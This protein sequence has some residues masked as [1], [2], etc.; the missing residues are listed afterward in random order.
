[1]RLLGFGVL[2]AAMLANIAGVSHASTKRFKLLV[3]GGKQLKWAKRPAQTLVLKYAFLKDSHNFPQARNCRR[4]HPVDA[5]AERSRL[6]VTALKREIVAGLRQWSAVADVV[7]EEA[8]TLA[9][10]DIV[11]GTR[12]REEG[13]AFADV[14][15]LGRSGPTDQIQRSLICFNAAHKWKIGFGGDLGRYDLRYVATHEAGHAIGLDHPG[16]SGELMS[17]RYGEDFR[18]L[19][20]GD[21]VGAIRLYGRARIRHSRL[22]SGRPH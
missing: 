7:F 18:G 8:S 16:R 22:I 17:F 19:Q 3:V 4:M 20:P 9:D 11:V 21:A 2:L 6:D 10:A 12:E 13:S 14:F 5:M 1:M 15:P